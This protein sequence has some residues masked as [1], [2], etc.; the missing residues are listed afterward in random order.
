[1]INALQVY[2]TSLLYFTERRI[3]EVKLYAELQLKHSGSS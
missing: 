2:L 3:N 1:M